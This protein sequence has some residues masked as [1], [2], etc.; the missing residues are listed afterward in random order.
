MEDSYGDPEEPEEKAASF[1]QDP[2]VERLRPEP[3]AKPAAAVILE[4]L[5][6][7]S[8]RDGYARL[9]LSIQH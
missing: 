1:E 8:A 5:A 9:C 3:S 2:L 7:R 6:G 4:G